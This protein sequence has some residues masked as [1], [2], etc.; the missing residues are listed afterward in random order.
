MAT[1]PGQL[2]SVL[3]QDV[4]YHPCKHVCK[5]ALKGNV[6]HLRQLLKDGA[7]INRPDRNGNNS[8]M[9][10][11]IYCNVYYFR[12]E[13]ALLL[14]AGG[15]QIDVEEATTPDCI[16]Q[17]VDKLNLKLRCI[18]AVR[19]HLLMLDPQT[20]LFVRV[21][22]LPLPTLIKRNLLFDMLTTEDIEQMCAERGETY[23]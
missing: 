19:K 15:E 13:I 17:T 7:V 16:K 12:P 2:V 11:N 8:L 22:H 6:Y 20:N 10:Y 5:T 1:Q 3:P 9:F 21:L 14:Y 23:V 4:Q 18:N